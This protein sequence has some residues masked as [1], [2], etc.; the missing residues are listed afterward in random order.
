MKIAENISWKTLQ[1]KVVAVN[2]T[3]GVYYT[4]NAVAS[5][6]WQAVARGLDEVA[7]LEYLQGEYE[8]VDPSQLAADLKE[9]LEQ[10]R[11]EKLL[12]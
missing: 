9:Q 7:L 11:V 2:V 8:G 3:S 10:W 1:D 12:E 6:I 5:D 4:M